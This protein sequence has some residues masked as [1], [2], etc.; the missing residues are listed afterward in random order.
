[1]GGQCHAPG[2]TRYPLYRSLGGP[3]GQSGQM[4]NISPPLGFDPRTVQP[5][6]NRYTDWAIPAPWYWQGKNEIFGEKNPVPVALLSHTCYMHYPSPTRLIYRPND[7][8]WTVQFLQLSPA[9]RC[10]LFPLHIL[11]RPALEHAIRQHRQWFCK[12]LLI[13]QWHS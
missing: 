1:M 12:V 7:I 5:V 11:Y 2:K 3:Q 4:R 8:W 10:A 6:A 13:R 9:A